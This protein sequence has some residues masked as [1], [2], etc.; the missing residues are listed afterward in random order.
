MNVNRE[1]KDQLAAIVGATGI[2]EGLDVSCRSTWPHGEGGTAATLLVRPQNTA[3]VARILATTS[4]LVQPVVTHGGRTGLV[5]GADSREGDL[6]LSTERMNAI[7]TIDPI[8][9]VAQVQAGVTLHG[10]QEA[11]QPYGLHFPM[12]LGARGTA[13]LGGM[14][15]TNAGGTRVLR[16]GMTR[17]Q[18][19]GLEVVLADGRVLSSMNCL[20]K[21]NTGYD[22]KQ[23]FIGSE[24]TLGVI[25]RLVLRLA[26]IPKGQSVALVSLDSFEGL[27]RFFSESSREL[28][29]GLSAF[30]VMWPDYYELVTTS[31]AKRAPPLP[32]G[33]EFYVLIETQST[34]IKM[35][36]AS[37]ESLLE[38]CLEEGVVSNSVIANSQ[39]EYDELWQMRED[40]EQLGRYGPPQPFDISLPMRD[41]HDYV[42][43]VRDQLRKLWPSSHCWVFGHIGDGNLH[44]A[45][46]AAED[47]TTKRA[48]EDIV[49]EPLTALGGSIS[50]EHGIGLER[51]D[52]L[53]L[54]RTPEEIAVMRGLKQFLDPLCLLNPGKLLARQVLA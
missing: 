20:V 7:E 26:E 30:E 49:Y 42:R 5:R 50:A 36:K 54:S 38:A 10:L 17:N 9:R 3:E 52:R 25:T 29:E 1:L 28:G 12:D 31:P 19:L 40:V 35:A 51:V 6:I 8:Q 4:A 21:N 22:L 34:D 27:L 44:L 41:M 13:T 43:T 47:P 2:L 24:G 14:A 37:L 23:L 11:L 46:R 15:A 39:R 48:V 33:S 53:G 18:I 32:H 45:I 16:Y